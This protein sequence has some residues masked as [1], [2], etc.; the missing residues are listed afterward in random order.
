MVVETNKE[1]A[2]PSADVVERRIKPTLIR[3]RAIKVETPPEAEIQVEAAQE[4]TPESAVETPAAV[5]APEPT[6]VS[7]KAPAPVQEAKPAPTPA[8]AAQ[9]AATAAAQGPDA[10][11]TV[12][13]QLAAPSEAERRIGVVGYIDLS[14]APGAVRGVKDDWKDRLKKGPRK[15][16]DRDELEMEAIQR[17]GGLK[18]FIG[19]HGEEEKEVVEVAAPAVADRVFQPGPAAKRRKTTVRKEFKQTQ[20]T[21][22]KAIKKVIRVEENI[23]VALLSQAIGVKASDIIK[24]LMA[25]NVMVTVNQQIDV[26]TASLIATDFGFSIEHTA[27]KEEDVLVEPEAHASAA[28]LEHRA[29]V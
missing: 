7:A 9:A 2:E 27:F 12:G 25:L 10:R 29:P 13:P 16:K 19:P 26:D 28:N 8:Q 22:P 17:A 14:A 20:I 6:E 21:E 11:A 15:R 23:T 5:A 18:Q 3:R 4:G 1:H 24:K